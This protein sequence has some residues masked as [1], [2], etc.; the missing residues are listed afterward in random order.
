VEIIRN[1]LDSMEIVENQED[2]RG[3]NL[4]RRI[5][6]SLI[7]SVILT[8][9]TILLSISWLTD[10]HNQ[11]SAENSKTM[12][13]GGLRGLANQLAYL[14]RDYAVWFE[15]EKRI[16]AKDGQW[17]TETMGLGVTEAGTFEALSVALP[18]NDPIYSWIQNGPLEATRDAV[19]IEIIN[20]IKKSLSEGF[21]QTGEVHTR[22][23]TIGGRPF[24]L[25]AA[26]VSTKLAVRVNPVGRPVMVIGFALDPGRIHE[27][28]LPFLIDDL[29]LDHNA[30]APDGKAS[31][32][33]NK[34]D[35]TTLGYLHWTPS[36]PGDS[37]FRAILPPVAVALVIFIGT[38]L[39][40]AG[41]A[42]RAARRLMESEDRSFKAARTD[43]LTGLAN[44]WRFLE[45][46]N[47]SSMR[48]ACERGELAAI[49]VDI[50]GFKHVND[51]IGSAGGDELIRQVARRLRDVLPEDAFFARVGG[52]EFNVLLRSTDP[53]SA[54]AKVAQNINSVFSGDFVLQGTLFHISASIGYAVAD[55]EANTVGELKRRADVAL[56]ESK[57]QGNGTPVAYTAQYE[58]VLRKNR[59]IETALRVAIGNGE[60]Q[61]FYQPI[62]SADDRSLVLVEALARWTSPDL[63]AVPP[64]V[65]IP[66]AEQCGLISALGAAIRDQ[67]C[68]DLAS[69]P[70]LKASLNA[71]PLELSDPNYVRS[72]KESVQIHGID[73]KRIEI[74]LT[75]GILVSHPEMASEKLQELRASGFSVALDDFGTGF[76]SIGYLREMP[77][78]KLKIDRSFIID[79]NTS[80]AAGSLVHSIASLGKGLGL[81]IT[82][83]G[84]ESEEHAILA[85]NAGCD[86]LQGY[87]FSKPIPIEELRK[88]YLIRAVGDAAG[89]A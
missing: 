71:S 81:H 7:G 44:R 86:Q 76:S 77:F 46:L 29:T 63:G 12:V 27:L 74:E 52:D 75:E 73:P 39:F 34:E 53:I 64:G 10:Q 47:G 60:I 51:S 3:V 69:W 23:E 79:I 78:D 14:T 25:A 49:F 38:G 83:E 24:L 5:S 88:A 59:N 28:G 35:G 65:F 82:A 36:K 61:P 37:V 85:V 42:Q 80:S 62:V 18:G 57:R 72:L 6:L 67:V 41:W 2:A 31:L 56:F 8:V 15:A 26:Y 87:H 45:K 16:L 68:R 17:I 54:S 21:R 89:P 1:A 58:S 66:V 33:V 84:I 40:M 55:D 20:D 43:S 50:A 32:P 22:Y 9:L 4:V 30:K 70:E 48:T 19:P 13:H 11:H